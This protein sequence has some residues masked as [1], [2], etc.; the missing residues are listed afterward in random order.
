MRE[1]RQVIAGGLLQRLLLTPV[2]TNARFSV[3]MATPYAS[4]MLESREGEVA[5]VPLDAFKAGLNPTDADL[6][7]FY[8]ANRNRYMIP[9]QRVLR[10]A[11]IGPEQVAGVT[12]SD[13][14]IAA[15]YNANKAS[16]AA[17]DTRTL[18]Q[19]IVPDQASAN[20]IAAKVKGGATIQRRRSG[21]AA[22]TSLKDQTREAYAGVAGDKAAAAVF[23][24]SAGRG[25]R[26]GPI[27]LRLG[28]GQDRIRSRP[29][30][31]SRSTRPRAKS[32][33]SSTSTSASR[34]SRTWST[35]SRTRSTTA[36]TSPR[37]RPRPRRR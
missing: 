15:Y 9:E 23:A 31:A 28:R 30:A 21:G 6:Q 18:S 5:M 19:A 11:R 22:V 1:V 10:I 35:R 13:Q 25:R 2:A 27:G 29:S 8:Q 4:M 14:E 20:A 33:P 37:R 17:K 34:R 16:Y 24:A 36:A 7:S 32:R 12:A 26:T 3:G